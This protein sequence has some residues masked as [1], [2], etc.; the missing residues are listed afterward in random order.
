MPNGRASPCLITYLFQRRPG[1]WWLPKKAVARRCRAF[2]R[3]S[4]SDRNSWHQLSTTWVGEKKNACVTFARVW[5]SLHTRCHSLGDFLNTIASLC[6]ILLPSRFNG[7]GEASRSGKRKYSKSPEKR[8][9][10][11]K[12][13]MRGAPSLT[14]GSSNTTRTWS[15]SRKS[16]YTLKT[17][18]FRG[19]PQ[20]LLKSINP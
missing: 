13:K 5:S 20:Q 6:I 19:S 8:L 12:F 1:R 4:L 16:N 7:R 2:Q 11:R 17:N 14:S 10:L 15:T 9:L 3:A 18:F